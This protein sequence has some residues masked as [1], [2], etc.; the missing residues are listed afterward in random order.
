MRKILSLAA[1]VATVAAP[2][3]ATV[4][5][6]TAASAQSAPYLSNPCGPTQRNHRVIGGGLGAVAG[7]IVGGNVAADN[8]KQEGKA[9]GAIAGAALG[10]EVGRRT[11]CQAVHR[12][13]QHQRYAYQPGYARPACKAVAGGRYVCLQPDGRWR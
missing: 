1:A 13:A 6:P 7:Y 9:L 5:L 12:Q 11:G 2:A 3:L 8:T 10:Q 4:A